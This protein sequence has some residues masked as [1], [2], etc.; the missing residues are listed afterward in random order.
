MEALKSTPGFLGTN[1]SLLA[2]INLVVHILFYIMLCLGVTAQLNGKYKWHDRLQIPVVVL[3]LF[4][5]AF[6]M[7]P[8]FM[9]IAPDVPA[10]LGQTFFL[11]PTLHGILGA[12]A[13][14]VAIYCLLAGL[15]ILP[16]KIGVLRYWMWLAFVLWTIVTLLG[17]FIYIIWY[18]G[19][20]SSSTVGEHNAEAVAEHAAPIAEAPTT[21]APTAEPVQEHAEQA[22]IEEPA[23]ATAEPLAEHAE[24]VVIEHAE[25]PVAVQPTQAEATTELVQEH[26][27]ETAEAVVAATEASAPPTDTPIPPTAT[28]LPAPSRIGLLTTSDEKVHG[29]KATLALSGVTP[30]PDGSVYEAWLSGAKQQP[31]SLGKLTL[32]GDT[33]NHTFV[34]PKGQ[35]LVGLYNGMFISVEPANDN[36]PAPSGVVA[37][38]AEIAPAV[39]EQVRLILAANPQTPNK[40]ALGLNMLNQVA[41]KMAQE[42][43]FQQDYSI[44]NNDLAALKIQAEGIVNIIE[45][46]G[47]ANFGDLDGNGEV[48]HTGDGFG[49]LG[50]GDGAGYLQAIAN[51]AAAA[52][53]AEGA[54]AE[55]KLRAEQ[56]QTAVDNAISLTEQI[57]DLE[58][59]ILQAPDIASATKSV[60]Q[61]AALFAQLNEADTTGLADPAKGGVRTVYNYSQL[62]A[63]ME[64]QAVSDQG[65]TAPAPAPTP[66]LIDEHAADTEHSGN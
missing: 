28:P 53:Q 48:Y 45:G 6:V 37:Y 63:A 16:R 49:L 24:E 46:Q 3:N 65:T 12:L 60:N 57:Q 10:N 58:L 5:I 35:I 39:L 62:I 9:N 44:T 54:T 23:K 56:T 41:D 66:E 34:N 43:G 31:L 29:D 47:G 36:N 59:Q 27:A 61:V 7:I 42:V 20:T 4:F 26:A 11:V 55:V 32:T 25:E 51:A 30:P 14:G 21:T 40:D 33:V 64:I 1:A 50:S 2:D 15:K 22:L 52:A 13:Q 17:I 8:S 18:T 38:Q 19:G